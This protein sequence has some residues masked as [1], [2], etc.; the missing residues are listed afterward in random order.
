MRARTAPVA[1]ALLAVTACSTSSPSPDAGDAAGGPAG[2]DATTDT[3]PGVDDL[4]PPE[5]VSSK[6]SS[7]EPTKQPASFA[8]VVAAVDGPIALIGS[9]GHLVAVRD[10]EVDDTWRKWQAH[11]SPDRSMAVMSI[12]PEVAR[13]LDTTRLAWAGLPDG[14]LA[15]ELELP[16]PLA[17]D[18]VAD[19]GQF[20]GLTTFAGVRADGDIAGPK[21]STDL[22]IAD[23]D[24]VVHRT[25]LDGNFVAEAFGRR[26][27]A[28]LPAQVFLLEY[29]PAEAPRFYRVRVYSTATGEVSLPLNLRDKS[30][31][32]DERMAGLSRSQVHADDEGLLFTLYRGT[33]DGT[34]DGEPYAFVH[35]LDL[36]DGVWC[37]DVSPELE[38][39]RLPGSLAV[40][41]DRLYVASANG[42]VG[43]FDVPSISDPDR[44]PTMD[45]VVEVGVPGAG[46]PA[47]PAAPP[48]VADADGVVLGVQ[49]GSQRLVR[50]SSTGERAGMYVTPGWLP[51]ALGRAGDELVAVGPGWTTFGDLD[52]PDWFGSAVAV[53]AG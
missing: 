33:I 49:D 12:Q 42:K 36:A 2:A 21:T 6:Q 52:L 51:T 5:S 31:Q 30:Q 43:S 19:G 44:S 11:V 46:A 24:G 34:P 41:D 8:P 35:T 50:I 26:I 39:D 14:E 47:V 48:L 23:R 28:G 25:S 18:A 7:G 13:R 16:G 22:V 1:V 15:D 40:A 20:V 17:V 53:I 32:V 45:W 38:L 37:L 3:L 29:V 10:G 27:E 4:A 9:D